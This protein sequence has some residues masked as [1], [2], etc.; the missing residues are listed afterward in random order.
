[1]E[2]LEQHCGKICGMLIKIFGILETQASQAQS[3][4]L[5]SLIK[6]TILENREKFIQCNFFEE[7]VNEEVL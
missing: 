3:P 7:R 5:N 2:T 4:M 1:M 6:K